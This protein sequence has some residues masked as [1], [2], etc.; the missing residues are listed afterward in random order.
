MYSSNNIFDFRLES[1]S[2]NLQGRTYIRNSNSD[3]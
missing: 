2:D 1:K 3:K